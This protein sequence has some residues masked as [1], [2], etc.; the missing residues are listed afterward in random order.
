MRCRSGQK[1]GVGSVAAREELAAVAPANYAFLATVFLAA[2]CRGKGGELYAQEQRA[3]ALGMRRKTRA[4]DKQC[5][6]LRPRTFLAGVFLAAGCTSWGRAGQLSERGP[7]LCWEATLAMPVAALLAHAPSWRPAPS[8]RGSSWQRASWPRPVWDG[9]R[10]VSLSESRQVWAVVR[11][12]P[13]ANA[14]A[15]RLTNNG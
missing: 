13:R 1:R 8:W 14:D 6:A 12:E 10:W 5:A 11:R 4:G 3:S 15:A 7:A 9:G 2:V